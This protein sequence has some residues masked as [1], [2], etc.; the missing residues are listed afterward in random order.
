MDQIV[1]L[2]DYGHDV[3]LIAVSNRCAWTPDAQVRL[4]KRVKLSHGTRFDP[5]SLDSTPAY[6]EIER[7]LLSL[8]FNVCRH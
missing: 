6:Q 2:K 5:L 3:V 7:T 4:A 8:G 1:V